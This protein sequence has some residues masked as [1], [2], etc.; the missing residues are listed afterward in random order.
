MRIDELSGQ[1]LQIEPATIRMGKL[2][3]TMVE[4]ET[5]YIDVYLRLPV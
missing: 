1:F 5:V 2:E 3:C 4:V